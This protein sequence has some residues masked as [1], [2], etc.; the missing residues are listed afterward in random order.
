[1]IQVAILG[2]TGTVGQKF[3]TL[4]QNHPQFKITE[5][6]ASEKSAGKLYKDACLW[7]QATPIPTEIA[8][9]TVQAHTDILSSPILF[10]GL[11]SSVA[12]DIEEHFAHKGHIVISN[13]KNHR[14]QDHVPLVIPEI[15]HIH[16]LGIAQQKYKGS[17]ITNPN[18]ATIALALAL[19]PLHK[20]FGIEKLLVHT[21]QAISGSGYP[22]VP[23]LDILGNVIPY[24]SDEEDKVET[25]PLKILGDY[26]AEQGFIPARF[27]ISAHCNRV[28]VVDGHTE[29]V[30]IQFINKPKKEQII[31]AWKAFKGFPQEEQLYLAPENP[32][33]YFEEDNRP[34]PSLDILHDKGMASSVGRLRPCNIFDYKFTVLGHNTIRG[35]AGS[36][37]LNAETM[38]AMGLL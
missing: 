10:S 34:Q 16:L 13:A 29:N 3:I 28:P 26:H 20:E 6:V 36:A 25:E 38:L 2:A 31:N 17:I 37:I 4:L 23:S 11:D 12:Y 9:T 8:N 33:W 27:D 18:C 32:V 24:I 21:L 30:S 22:G 7:K 15:N 14:M 19:A 5:L 1:M 35:A